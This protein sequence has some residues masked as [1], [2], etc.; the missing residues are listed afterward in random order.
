MT[1]AQRVRQLMADGKVWSVSMLRDGLGLAACGLTEYNHL[2]NSLSELRRRGQLVRVGKGEYRL[3]PK[4][5]A[6]RERDAALLGAVVP[7]SAPNLPGQAPTKAQERM[8]LVMRNL[9][10]WSAADLERLS[11]QPPQVVA[12]YVADLEAG[13]I[14]A[15][16]SEIE[17]VGVYQVLEGQIAAP[18]GKLP[19]WVPEARTFLEELIDHLC[20]GADI[21]G[22][23]SSWSKLMGI[24]GE[25]VSRFC[26]E[27]RERRERLDPS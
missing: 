22:A 26:R 16:I 18:A 10:R 2:T 25:Q 12:T 14:V 13:G 9:P 7:D 1:R 23:M 4:G 20:S 17:G 24:I 27:F 19:A 6:V 11:D 5:V 15:R 3:S 8:W 21:D